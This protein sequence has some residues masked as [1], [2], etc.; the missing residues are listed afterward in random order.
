MFF[1]K[2]LSKLGA[3]TVPISFCLLIYPA[4][5]MVSLVCVWF[6]CLPPPP[7]QTPC[8]LIVA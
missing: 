8:P 6:H 1:M 2:T 5:C 7:A 3:L 4:F